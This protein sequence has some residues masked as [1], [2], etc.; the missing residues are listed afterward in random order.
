MK[1]VT[2]ISAD[3]FNTFAA[4]HQKNHFL[5][6]YEW[7]VF[8]SKSPDWSFD[9]VGLEDHA[10][11][12]V[13]GALVL[14]RFLPIIKRPF[15]YVPRGY[16]IDFNDKQLMKTF[17]E[18][19]RQYAKSKKAIFIKIDPDLKY[20]DR[21]VDGEKV[22]GAIENN[23]LLQTLTNLGYLH[24]GFTQDFD[25]SIQP[26]YTFRLDL[27]P[28]E[29]D[30]LQGCQSKTRYNIKVAQKKGI[31]I[32]EGTREDLKT[33]EAIMRVTGERDG[34]L[35]RPL[36]YFE[37]M[38]DTLAPN[39]MCKLYLA[40]LNTKHALVNIEEELVQTQQS[41]ANL[42]TQL[43]NEEL[44]EKK[45]QK[46]Q[47][48]LEPET[49]KLKNLIQQKEEIQKLYEEHPTG[50]TMSGIIATYFGNKSWYLYG[51]SDNMYRE[52]MPNYYIQWQAFTEA[53]QNGYEI[54]DFFGISGKTDE[55]DHL[56]GLYRFKKGFGGEFT[57]FIGEFDYVI[58]PI[59]Y[60]AWTKLLPQFKKFKKKL[61]SKKH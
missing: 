34:F 59:G 50:I 33:F 16:I 12:L 8:K 36:S 30:L 42:Q 7:G 46:I 19:M 49:N 31:E 13:A 48:K 23:E 28:S 6:S 57:E 39:G 53:K 43:Q 47:N 44:S 38:Y 40:K 18:S 29:K 52:F 25:S 58:D 55:S 27:I 60:F 5:Q 35:T 41:I 56:Y 22:E 37:D 51:A 26:R 17:T 2:N 20:V 14:I 45:R 24:L 21:T 3:R 11:N 10:G 54:Y 32:V 9:T 1:F 4:K 61:R 15:L